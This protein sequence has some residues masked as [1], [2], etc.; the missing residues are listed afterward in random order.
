MNGDV[1]IRPFDA[2][3]SS[4]KSVKNLSQTVV[5]GFQ[6]SFELVSMVALNRLWGDGN[7]LLENQGFWPEP[8]ELGLVATKVSV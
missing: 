3:I 5:Y 1:S 8:Q 6:V 4:E 7:P 2:V